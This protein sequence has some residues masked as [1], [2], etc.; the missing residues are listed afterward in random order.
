MHPSRRHK[1]FL[2]GICLLAILLLL[3]FFGKPN[4]R[5]IASAAQPGPRVPPKHIPVLP[6]RED[7]L[8][9][10]FNYFMSQQGAPPPLRELK[11]DKFIIHLPRF[12]STPSVLYCNNSALPT[13]SGQGFEIKLHPA[14]GSID[15]WFTRKKEDTL[16]YVLVPTDILCGL[17]L[18]HPNIR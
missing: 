15:A 6:V 7:S 12:S 17:M 18:H 14:N 13:I 5:T 1:Y 11:P 3:F 10:L 4:M 2:L 9:Q 8:M 16:Y